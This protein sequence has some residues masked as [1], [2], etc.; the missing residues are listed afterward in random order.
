MSEGKK[1]L[2]RPDIGLVWEVEIALLEVLR[3]HLDRAGFPYEVLAAPPEPENAG[4]GQST[5]RRRSS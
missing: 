4:E 3:S 2:V 1:Y 5:K